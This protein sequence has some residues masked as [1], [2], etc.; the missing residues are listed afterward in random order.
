MI[1][2]AD[3]LRIL[4][5][6][7][8]PVAKPI[9]GGQIR[10]AEIVAA[11]RRRGLDTLLASVWPDQAVYRGRFSLRQLWRMRQPADSLDLPLPADALES[12]RGQTAPFIADLASGDLVAADDGRLSRIEQFCR[13]PVDWVHVEQPWLLPVALRLRERMRLGPFRLVYGSQN[14]EYRLKQGILRQYG[15]DEAV[16]DAVTSAVMTLEQEAAA[17]ADVVAAVTSEDARWLAPHARVEPVLAANGVR[18]WRAEPAALARWRARLGA[19]PFALFVASAHPP[20]ITG[21]GESFGESL[22]A[23]SPVQRIVLAGSVAGHIVASDWFCRWAALNR[24]RIIAL[25]MLDQVDLDAIRELAGVFIVP[26]TSGGGSNLKTAEALYS[27]RP[28]VATPHAMRGFEH[29]SDLSGVVV[30]QPGADFSQAVHDSLLAAERQK[31]GR[32]DMPVAQPGFHQDRRES[33]TWSQT[34]AGLVAAIADA[35]CAPREHQAVGPAAEV[36]TA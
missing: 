25:G 16:T 18:P 24:R 31:D 4:V 35:G 2:N 14:V 28:V 26:V 22:A 29:L 19:E 5:L 10:L 33:L 30:A 7:S 6:G 13:R 23:L 20:N 1:P 21:F 36:V 8:Y 15:V 9:H 3:A 34:L 12:Y 27:G 11:Y 32:A 17:A